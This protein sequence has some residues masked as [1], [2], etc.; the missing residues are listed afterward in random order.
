MPLSPANTRFLISISL[1][2]AAATDSLGLDGENSLDCGV[3]PS[4]DNTHA[5][6]D[7]GGFNLLQV[8][9]VIRV[10]RVVKWSSLSLSQTKRIMVQIL[11]TVLKY[12]SKTKRVFSVPEK[13]ISLIP[14]C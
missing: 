12:K 7:T 1:F 9:R 11:G 8:V 14:S 5:Q 4:I 2:W 6:M 10:I 13:A 3:V